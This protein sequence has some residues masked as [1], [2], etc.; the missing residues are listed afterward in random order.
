MNIR[1]IPFVDAHV[2]LWDLKRIHYPWLT[3]PFDDCGPNG[4]VEPIASDYLL[5]DYL[6]ETAGWNVLGIV[7]VEAGADP[8]ASLHETAWLQE[9]ADNR[10]LPQAIVAHADLTRPDLQRTLEAQLAHANV[11]GIRHIVNW[12]PSPLRTYT[13]QDFTQDP[14]WWSG[15]GLLGKLRLSFDLQAYPNQFASV[16]QQLRRYPGTQIVLNHA[17]MAIPDD[18]DGWETWRSGVQALAEL[19]NVACK[20]SGMGFAQRNWN[21]DF[22]RPYV[23]ET[24]EIF[25]THRTMFASDFPTDRLFGTFEHTLGT[26]AE[27]LSGFSEDEQ[28]DL[29]GRNAVRIY[30]LPL[31]LM[32]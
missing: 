5:D 23:L 26:Y 21:A 29:F 16:A 31:Q 1:E 28:R 10:G 27:I 9:I 20:I 4:S 3:P 13:S 30:R 7:H 25:G 32:S 14:I 15:L 2:H 12:H 22:A 24:I 19:P 18:A 11:R 17:G 8:S 6:S